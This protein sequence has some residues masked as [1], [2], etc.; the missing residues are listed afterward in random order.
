M[1][2][3]QKNLQSENKKKELVKFLSK[4]YQMKISTDESEDKNYGNLPGHK[5][6]AYEM[7]N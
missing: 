1:Q 2:N 4:E 6:K 7:K 5:A 3:A